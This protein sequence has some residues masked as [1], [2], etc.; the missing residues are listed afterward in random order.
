M[1]NPGSITKG[2]AIMAVAIVVMV[3]AVGAVVVVDVTKVVAGAACS[4][5][6]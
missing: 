4:N 3:I 1:P 6:P 5:K 2:V